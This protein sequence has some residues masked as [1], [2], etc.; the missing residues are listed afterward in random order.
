VTPILV[1]AY[2]SIVH[3]MIEVFEGEVF[4]FSIRA[5]KAIVNGLPIA[6][7]A[8]RLAH[9]AKFISAVKTGT[10]TDFLIRVSRD[11]R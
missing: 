2:F 11:T 4:L 10:T 3:K 5:L 1:K 9:F 8:T 7:S 6:G